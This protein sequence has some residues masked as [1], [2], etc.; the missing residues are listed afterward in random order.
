V[1]VNTKE[2]IS[3]AARPKAARLLGLRVRIPPGPR[4]SVLSVVGFQVEVSATGSSL[5]QRS[6]TECGVSECDREISMMRRPWP[7]GGG[8][9]L[10]Y[11]GEKCVG[12]S[13]CYCKLPHAMYRSEV[14]MFFLTAA[15]NEGK[16]MV[17]YTQP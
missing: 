11:N 3:M 8:G 1:Y 16:R 15:L 14:H 2:T 7:T 6:P 12:T 9:R 10:L 4:M 5:V 17:S 13:L